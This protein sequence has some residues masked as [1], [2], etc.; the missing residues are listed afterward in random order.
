MFFTLPEGG[1]WIQV[2]DACI[3]FRT[4]ESARI[5]Q[6]RVVLDLSQHR[7]GWSVCA[8][9]VGLIGQEMQNAQIDCGCRL[10]LIGRGIGASHDAGPTSSRQRHDHTSCRRLRRG[11]HTDQRCMRGPDHHPPHPPGRSQMR[12]IAGQRL[13]FVPVNLSGRRSFHQDWTPALGAYRTWCTSITTRSA[14]RAADAMKMCC[15]SQ[16]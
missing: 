13:R 16:R 10:R 5:R 11:Q 2:R 1:G 7:A 14:W 3:P 4:A 8:A 15:I 12:A 6:R 9:E